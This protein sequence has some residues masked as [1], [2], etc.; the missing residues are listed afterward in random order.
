M[1]FSFTEEQSML[2][3]SVASYLADHYDFDG[4]PG[5]PAIGG[6]MAARGVEGVRGGSRHPGAS[7]SEDLGA[8]AAAPPRPCGHGGIGKALVVEPISAPS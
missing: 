6:G 2:R 1:D 4:P 3:D 8:W 7:F 5:G